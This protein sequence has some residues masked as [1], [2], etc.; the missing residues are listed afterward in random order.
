MAVQ[1]E[2]LRRVVRQALGLLKHLAVMAL[3]GRAVEVCQA[4]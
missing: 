1:V 4:L 2:E 3:L